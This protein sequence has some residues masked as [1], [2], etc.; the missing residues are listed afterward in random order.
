MSR[1]TGRGDQSLTAQETAT[2]ELPIS[3]DGKDA[4]D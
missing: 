4:M 2:L 1:N 3:G